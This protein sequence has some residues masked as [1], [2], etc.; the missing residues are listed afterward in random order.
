MLT[1]ILH[2]IWAES[3]SNY[4]IDLL[5]EKFQNI[6][7][8]TTIG[9]IH[10]TIVSAERQRAVTQETLTNYFNGV[11]LLEDFYRGVKID[12][13]QSLC[14]TFDQFMDLSPQYEWSFIQSS[15]HCRMLTVQEEIL[16]KN[17]DINFIKTF[18]SIDLK[19]IG[20]S[21][22]LAVRLLEVNES[23][24]AKFAL[25]TCYQNSKTLFNSRKIA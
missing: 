22:I 6:L 4:H 17:Y 13:I 1:Q 21:D 18:S 24:S 8:K 5:T 12:M 14:D 3:R 2:C 9:K 23:T 7:D 16:L 25:S 20:L 19:E 10:L 15:F 11:H